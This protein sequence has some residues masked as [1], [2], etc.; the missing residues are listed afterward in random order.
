MGLVL[1]PIEAYQVQHGPPAAN[2]GKFTVSYLHDMA[3]PLHIDGFH[4][5][6]T[7]MSFVFFL[8]CPWCLPGEVGPIRDD[9]RKR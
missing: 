3:Q 1:P 6:W 4:L 2:A 9:M 5:C 7:K 8:A